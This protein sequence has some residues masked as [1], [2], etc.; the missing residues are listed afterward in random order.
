MTDNRNDPLQD[1]PRCDP[2]RPGEGNA[3]HIRDVLTELLGQYEVRF[4]GIHVTV[5]KEPSCAA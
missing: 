4:P 5:V 3:R 2:R 1:E